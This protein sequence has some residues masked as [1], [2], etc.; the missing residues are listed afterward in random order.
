[1]WHE[2]VCSKATINRDAEMTWRGADVLITHT[3]RR[4]TPTTDPRI[5][6][7]L[8]AGLYVRIGACAFNQ[9]GDLVPQ[10]EGQSAPRL[11]VEFLAAAE[12]KVSIL[13]VQIGMTDPTT[14]DPHKGFGAL[15]LRRFDDGL[16]QRGT[17]GV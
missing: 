6:R 5:D 8:G 13:H 17:V 1:V 11:Y 9:P 15:W 14:L 3:A 12:Q 2:Y 4:A 7:D 16:A 10:C